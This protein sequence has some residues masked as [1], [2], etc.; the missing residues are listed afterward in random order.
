MRRVCHLVQELDRW[1]HQFDNAVRLFSCGVVK[2]SSSWPI[3]LTKPNKCA[4]RN[5]KHGLALQMKE[6]SSFSF[7]I[8]YH[9]SGAEAANEFPG[10]LGILGLGNER[11]GW[12]T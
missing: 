3:N 12:G 7:M 1:E 4:I 5:N 2:A 11:Y 9:P 8:A 6:N 10:A